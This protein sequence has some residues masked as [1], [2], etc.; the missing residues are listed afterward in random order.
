MLFMVIERFRDD[1]LVPAYR[2]VRDKGR[3][4]PPGLGYL[5]SW[6]EV[7]AGR[8]FQLMECDDAALMQQWI[9]EWRGSGVSFEVV[10]VITSKQMQAIVAP[11]L[12][13]GAG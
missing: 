5:H 13:D 10:P 9:L 3:R 8:C 4:L 6:I 1:D 2:Q 7:G 11:H 12:D